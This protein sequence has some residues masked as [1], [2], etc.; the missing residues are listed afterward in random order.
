MII[1]SPFNLTL[2]P[3]PP[4][5][6]VEASLQHSNVSSCFELCTGRNFEL[7]DIL[8]PFFSRAAESLFKYSSAEV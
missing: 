5:K 1:F 7:A 4:G 6:P 3:A 2:I 8:L